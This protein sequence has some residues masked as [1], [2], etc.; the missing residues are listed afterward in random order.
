MLSSRDYDL[1][2]KWKGKSIPKEIILKGIRTAFSEGFQNQIHRKGFNPSLFRCKPYIDAYLAEYKKGIKPDYP[3]LEK[4]V[5]KKDY[6]KPILER[7]NKVIITEKRQNVRMEYI[8]SRNRLLDIIDSDVNDIFGEIREIEEDLFENV[9][10]NISI[11]EQ[12]K[13]IV[14]A[15]DKVRNRSKIMSEQA[16]SRSIKSYRNDILQKHYKIKKIATYA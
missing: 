15:Q 4:K 1:I 16:R 9:F 5:D 13:I 14:K 3:N 12:N 6:L 11:N 10:Q 8:R 2:L 7:L